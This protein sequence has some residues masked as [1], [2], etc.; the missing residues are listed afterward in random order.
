[1]GMSKEAFKAL[2]VSLHV[3][4]GLC[5][6]QHVS[7]AEQ[8]AIFLQ[9][10][11]TGMGNREQQEWFQRSREK[12]SKAFHCIL[13]MLVLRPFY[14]SYIKLP[15]LDHI[16]DAI[17]NSTE[18]W[19]WF[20]DCLGAIDGSLIYSHV[21]VADAAQ[22]QNQKG[23]L[24]QN[25]FA[26]CQFDLFFIYLLCASKY[27][28][29]DAGFPSG[30]QRPKN[31]KELFN[32]LHAHLYNAIEQ[33]FGLVKCRFG[34]L[35]AAP[36]YNLGTQA[37]IPVACTALHNFIQLHDPKDPELSLPEDDLT[38]SFHMSVDGMALSSPDPHSQGAYMLPEEK[39]R[40]K[41]FCDNLAQH[42]WEHYVANNSPE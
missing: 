27:Y 7:A 1:M 11:W 22:C 37:C 41:A 5:P 32:L 21:S 31:A 24:S 8:L 10:A 33:I 38:I 6:T 3:K 23:F 39:E 13:N 15:S 4:T 34:I 42:M 26:A 20:K 25:I 17:Q 18:F 36:E 16:P 30:S 2:V 28:L 9:M 29:E 14:S 35:Q 12:I 19:P 40:A